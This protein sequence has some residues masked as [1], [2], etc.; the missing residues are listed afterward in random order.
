MGAQWQKVDIPI[1]DDLTPSERKELG[2]L[3]VE[4]I[5]KRTQDGKDKDG[6]RFPKYSKGYIKSLD[7]KNAGKSPSKIDLQL[8]GDMLA[9]LDVLKVSKDT[10]RVGFARGSDENAK[11]DGNIRGTYGSSSPNSSKARDFLGIK[12][13]ELAKLI[14]F[15]KR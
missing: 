2:D 5:V 8:S 12:D 11:A 13:S 15:V 14:D 6:S 9:A 10:I 7:F 1:P 3:I 4:T